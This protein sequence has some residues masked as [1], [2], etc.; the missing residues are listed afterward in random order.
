MPC[1]AYCTIEEEYPGLYV[2]DKDTSTTDEMDVDLEDLQA[3][4]DDESGCVDDSASGNVV[5][6][7]NEMEDTDIETPRQEHRHL[8]TGS[9]K[10]RNY[11]KYEI[12]Y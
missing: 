11:F 2:T 6:A 5:F 1:A 7:D 9:R 3:G 12:F 4:D 8:L 10:A